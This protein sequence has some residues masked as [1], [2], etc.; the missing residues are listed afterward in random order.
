MPNVKNAHQRNYQISKS[1]HFVSWMSG[2]IRD[3]CVTTFRIDVVG[4]FYDEVYTD[5]WHQ[6]VKANRRV[7]FFAYT[8]SWTK[9]S[10]FAPLVG[11]GNEKNMRLWFSFDS[12]MPVPPR[13]RG[14]RRCYLSTS[15][16]DMPPPGT[17]NLIFRDNQETVLKYSPEGVQICPYDNG[18]TATTCSKCKLCWAKKTGPARKAVSLE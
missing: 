6:V 8:R 3:F 10:L 5:K 15:D 18:V 1:E 4:D 13:I 11:L 9:P 7:K 17:A 16:T 14:I 2:M 12:T